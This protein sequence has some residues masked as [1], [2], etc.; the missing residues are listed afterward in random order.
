MH[1][2][3]F[4]QEAEL[5]IARHELGFALLRECGRKGTSETDL[6][7]GL[8]VGSSISQSTIN[9]MELNGS[10]RELAGNRL[11]SRVAILAPD[12][13]LDLCVVGL[14]HLERLVSF[15]GTLQEAC[16]AAGLSGAG[17]L[18]HLLQFKKLLD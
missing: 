3:L 13:V 6:V 17:V 10:C 12:D 1:L 7:S 14:G 8:K 5:W 11:P 4:L 15:P 16:K 2:D 18:A 9:D